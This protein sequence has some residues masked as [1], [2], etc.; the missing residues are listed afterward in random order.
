MTP[1]MHVRRATGSKVDVSEGSHSLRQSRRHVGK[2]ESDE[3]R[4]MRIVS[5]PDSRTIIFQQG[6]WVQTIR[7]QGGDPVKHFKASSH[8]KLVISPDQK[9]V[10]VRPMV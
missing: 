8:T 5:S 3:D 6:G 9:Q 7:L 10:G 1:K 4:A 2:R